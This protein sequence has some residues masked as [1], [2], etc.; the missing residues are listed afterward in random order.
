MSTS[1]AALVAAGLKREHFTLVDIGCS[2]GIDPA[3]RVFGGRLRAIGFDASIDECERLASI[4]VSPGVQYAAGFVGLPADHP[5]SVKMKD[6]PPFNRVAFYRFSAARVLALEAKRIEK[7]SLAEQLRFNAWDKARLADRDQ[8]VVVPDVL[9]KMGWSDVDFL[10]ID[11]DGLD[12]QVLHSFDTR[13]EDYGL[14]AAKLEVCLF[15][16]ADETENTFHNTDRFMRSRGFELF[17][18]DIRRYSMAALPAR[19]AI[20][21]PAQTVTGRPFQADALYARDLAGKDWAGMAANM[22]GEKLA[23]LAAIFSVWGQPDSAAE[24][25]VDFRDRLQALFDVDAGLDLL[26]AQG[27]GEMK[28]PLSY[29]EYV[30][31]F[32][33]NHERFYP[34]ADA[35]SQPEFPE[36]RRSTTLGERLRAAMR[37]LREPG[38]R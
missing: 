14:L 23:K 37:A 4:E 21:A 31:T 26:A 2:G 27:Q 20:T 9:Q 35:A 33:A 38:A 3:W 15:G 12:Y 34:A 29:R 22:S 8:P 30:A 19:F 25:L 10:K 28:S 36:G 11:I 6:K 17:D 13:L 24:I 32:E 18:L 16:N 7:S 5:F 1:L